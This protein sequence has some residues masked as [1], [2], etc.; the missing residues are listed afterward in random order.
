ML[1]KRKTED[2]AG[3]NEAIL[4]FSGKKKKKKKE[5]KVSRAVT[6]QASV[7]QDPDVT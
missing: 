6:Q 5:N 3:T 7:A 4:K 1:S 2:L